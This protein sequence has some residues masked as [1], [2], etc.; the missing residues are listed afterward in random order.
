MSEAR[1]DATITQ[2]RKTL[3]DDSREEYA[4]YLRSSE[5]S[6]SFTQREEVKLTNTATE[7]AI[8]VQLPFASTDLCML[9]T[10]YSF[11][12]QNLPM[13]AWLL[14]KQLTCDHNQNAKVTICQDFHNQ[15]QGRRPHSAL[16]C[17]SATASVQLRVLC[18]LICFGSSWARRC[19]C[20][21]RCQPHP[22]S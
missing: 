3:L 18:H 15:L 7:T 13:Q 2:A 4:C 21:Q 22:E 8:L 9:L 12:L 14:S 1:A 19:R 17:R 16:V 6:T 10:H 5:A 20:L 11:I